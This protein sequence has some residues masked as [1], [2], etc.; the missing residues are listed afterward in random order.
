VAESFG[1]LDPR[2]DARAN[3]VEP[4]QKWTGF[5]PIE[6]RLWTKGTTNGTAALGAGLV[7]NSKRLQALVR[8]VEL[9]PAQVGNGAIELLN[10]VSKSKITGEEERYSRID[11]LD[12][13]ANIEGARAAFAAIEPALKAHDPALATLID[14]RFA[15]VEAGLKPYARGGGTY[16]SYDRLTKPQIRALSQLIDQLAEPLSRAPAIAV[17]AGKAGG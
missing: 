3:D 15:D 6:Q 16:V 1:D 17:G 4:G 8:A 7:A 2:L 14:T 12:F 5:H 13:A 9:E 11:L 10:E